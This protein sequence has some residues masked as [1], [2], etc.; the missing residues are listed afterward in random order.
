MD[1]PHCG[2]TV[3]HRDT[4]LEWA[5]KAT[6]WH[7]AMSGMLVPP[8]QCSTFVHVQAIPTFDTIPKG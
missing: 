7:L 5:R 3:L 2:H 6:G 1:Y 4:R 8:D